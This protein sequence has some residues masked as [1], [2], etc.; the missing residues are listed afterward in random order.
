M[1]YINKKKFEVRVMAAG[2]LA[3][4]LSDLPYMKID[5]TEHAQEFCCMWGTQF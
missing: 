2:I 1:T 3:A 5:T 4:M